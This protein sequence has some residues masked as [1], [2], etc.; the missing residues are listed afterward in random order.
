M[1]NECLRVSQCACAYIECR[2]FVCVR[3]CVGRPLRDGRRTC[4]VRV[5][6]YRDTYTPRG[7]RESH[8]NTR[9]H[10]HW[11]G[12][13]HN[14]L[15]STAAPLPPTG[16][17]CCYALCVYM[18]DVCLCNVYYWCGAN[19]EYTNVTNSIE[20]YCNRCCCY[21]LLLLKLK[22]PSVSLKFFNNCYDYVHV[23]T[24]VLRP[25]SG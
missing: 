1:T 7:R 10:A 12:H 3:V 23:L 20:Y 19:S 24:I 25:F 18:C 11:H 22:D 4:A 2:R 13:V 8:V 9:A 16:P 6:T 15:R 5:T 14:V 21:L 17:C